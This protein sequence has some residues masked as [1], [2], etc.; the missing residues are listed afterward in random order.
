MNI[1]ILKERKQDERR[2]SLQ[3]H[4][5]G[6]LVD[7]GHHIF[8]ETGAGEL[9][10]YPDPAYLQAGAEIVP[11]QHVLDH[12]ELLLKVKCPIAEEYRDYR[13]NQILFT[14]L[15]FDENLSKAKTLELINSGFLGIA[16]EW[17]EKDGTYPLL[18]SMSKMTG[19]LFYQRSVELLA[20][21]KGVLAGAYDKALKGA[22]ILIIGLGRI[23]TGVLKC[24]L[25]NKLNVIVVARNHQ[26]VLDKIC[27][28]FGPNRPAE[29]PLIIPFDN[30]EHE[31]CKRRISELM[32]KLDIVVNC[33]VRRP[34]LP[35]EK[36][37][38]FIDKAMIQQM[39]PHSIVCDATACDRDF[40]E[41]CVSSE[42]LTHYDLID[43][44]IHYSPDHIP[45]YVPKSSTELLTD[46]TFEYVRLIANQG[47]KEAIKINEALRK[48]VSC[49]NGSITH[50]YT[51]NKKG[52]EYVDIL[53]IL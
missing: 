24:S 6:Q 31:E 21:H 12:C 22:T 19:Y 50:Q 52:F 36:M 53:N 43:G 23:G 25:L 39:Q 42:S 37:E 47:I 46:A 48:G 33:A 51:A 9:A 27:A 49:Y 28:V 32:P 35:K 18:E 15:H 45:S 13:A 7:D 17:V 5:A 3:P 34:N 26:Q 14:Y 2:V 20:Q 29:P 40:I 8:V 11:K 38:Y 44:V 1:G 16:Y 10:Q 41:T 4:Q 30:D